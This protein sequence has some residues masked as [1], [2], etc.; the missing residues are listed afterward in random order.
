MA[1][2]M[3]ALVRLAYIT[4]LVSASGALSPGPLTFA[5]LALGSR[6]GWKGGLLV[7]IG[8]SLVELPYILVLFAFF[9][10]A[11]AILRGVWGDVITLIGTAIVLFFASAVARDGLRRLRSRGA[12]DSNKKWRTLGNPLVVGLLFTGFNVWFL[13]WWLSIG[14]ELIST[15]VSLGLVSLFVLFVSHVWL[16]YLWLGFLAEAGKRG[17]QLIGSRGYA[18][19]LIVLGIILALFG[20]N[21]SLK[22]F[23]PY[24][25]IP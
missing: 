18:I 14:L 25:I 16:D 5:T 17:T 24:T 1:I 2:A 9:S 23:T 7:A 21:M 4:I 22:R 15:A 10:Y 19:L 8:H 20:V 11:E 13:I 3:D 6:Y 12:A